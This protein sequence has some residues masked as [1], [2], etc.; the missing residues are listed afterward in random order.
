MP[1]AMNSRPNSAFNLPDG[2]TDI[3]DASNAS[4]RFCDTCSH[5]V[6]V[7]DS[8]G[9]CGLE[10]ADAC[11]DNAFTS[12]FGRVSPWRVLEWVTDNLHYTDVETCSRWTESR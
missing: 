7:A 3:P 10:F 5:C 12:Q 4:D 1:I 6:H 9:V 11:E 2:V 8:K